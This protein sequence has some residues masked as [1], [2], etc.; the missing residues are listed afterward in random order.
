MLPKDKYI[1][2]RL[3]AMDKAFPVKKNMCYK[4]GAIVMMRSNTYIM[5]HIYNGSVG[6]VTSITD[7]FIQVK[8]RDLCVIDVKKHNFRAQ[9][10]ESVEAVL[11]QYPLSLA[12]AMTIHKAQGLTM[13]KILLDTDCFE[14]GQLY[15]ALS[16]IKCLEDLFMTNFNIKSVRTDPNALKYESY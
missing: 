1:A 3:I 15:T 6:K 8:F 12:W 14:D 5:Q 7:D 16:R 9:C 4:V 13:D 2:D 11:Y 10:G